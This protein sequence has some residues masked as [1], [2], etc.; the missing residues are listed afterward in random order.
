MSTNETVISEDAKEAATKE[1]F[2]KNQQP[3]S[4]K[5]G[6][7]VQA[8]L[9]ASTAWLLE[10][11]KWYDEFRNILAKE[12]D[13]STEAHRIVDKVKSIKSALQTS[14]DLCEEIRKSEARLREAESSALKLLLDKFGSSFHNYPNV[15][16]HQRCLDVLKEYVAMKDNP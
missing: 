11:S 4:Y 8:L 10:E 14:R 16:S 2:S 9:N 3:S 12:L 1:V 15:P 6:Y 5:R 7:H 13:C